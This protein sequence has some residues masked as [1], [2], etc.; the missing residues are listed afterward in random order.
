MYTYALIDP[1]DEPYATFR[2]HLRS[3]GQYSLVNRAAYPH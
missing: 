3:I 2:Y 1:I